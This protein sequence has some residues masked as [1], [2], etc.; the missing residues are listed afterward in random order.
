MDIVVANIPPKYGMLLPR[1]WGEKLQSTL[2][3]DIT[4]AT[5]PVFGKRRRLYRKALMKFM[6]GRQEKPHNY[7]LYFVH[8]DLDSFIIYNDGD[9]NTL[10]I[11]AETEISKIDP[12]QTKTI[13]PNTLPEPLWNMI[14]DGSCSKYGFRAGVWVVNTRNNNA[15]G[16]SHTQNFQCTNNV[17]EYEALILGLQLLKKLGAKRISIQG[18]A[19]II[20]KQIKEVYLGKHPKMREYI[21][22]VLDFLE[23]FLE[24][25]IS[26]IPG[27]STGI[28]LRLREGETQGHIKPSS[29]L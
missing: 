8:T 29:A 3:M 26:T 27:V 22:V 7:P 15:K 13:E 2:Q 9:I 21:N 18:D 1:L 6:V 11:N 25:D 24:Y 17:V 23:G 4:F 28:C 10:V 19:E 14:F 20:I 12:N 5:I 16:H